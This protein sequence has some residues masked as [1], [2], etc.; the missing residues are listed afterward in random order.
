MPK[1][2]DKKLDELAEFQEFREKFLPAIRRDLYKG[3]PAKEIMEKYKSLA[4]ARKVM[5]LVSPNEDTADRAATSILDRTEGKAKE[6][7]E[8]T[9]RYESL[10]EVELEAKLRSLEAENE[11]T[12]EEH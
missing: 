2:I 10:S 8:V 7:Q 12:N 11:R 3:V 5:N 4:A 9:H 1:E 6:K